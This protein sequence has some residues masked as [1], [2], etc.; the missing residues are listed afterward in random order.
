MGDTAQG[1]CG[2]R[3][4]LP[5][6]PSFCSC[7][8]CLGAWR[9]PRVRQA[10]GPGSRVMLRAPPCL[11]PI[12][13]QG[14]LSPS[15]SEAGSHLAN[16]GSPSPRPSPR[17]PFPGHFQTVLPPMPLTPVASLQTP[18]CLS[19]ESLCSAGPSGSALS[20]GPGLMV[21]DR[22]VWARGADG[23]CAGHLQPWTPQP[24]AGHFRMKARLRLHQN[25]KPSVTMPPGHSKEISQKSI[26]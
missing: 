26:P 7:L 1:L 21:C 8:G 4:F 20:L 16:P 24:Q 6:A 3:I 11:Y 2:K 15:P 12:F 14:L 9:P 5:Q 10:L 23:N 25:M 22:W 13:H 18:S 19:P 17:L